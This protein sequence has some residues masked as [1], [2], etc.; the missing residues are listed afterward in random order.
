MR[1]KEWSN[2]G[3]WQQLFESMHTEADTEVVMID[4]KIVRLHACC[5]GYKKDSQT[6]L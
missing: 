5:A 2:K 1:F 6:Q 4:T 3:I